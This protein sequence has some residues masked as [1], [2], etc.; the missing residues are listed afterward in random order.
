MKY[1]K[2]KNRMWFEVAKELD[3]EG[4]LIDSLVLLEPDAYEGQSLSQYLYYRLLCLSFEDE[5]GYKR[6]LY[7]PYPN[8]L[9]KRDKR[10]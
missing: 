7:I 2:I 9:N 4:K 5:G 1:L 10:Q 3:K 6:N 8:L